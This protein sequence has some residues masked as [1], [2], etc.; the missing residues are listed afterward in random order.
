MWLS[1]PAGIL[2][3]KWKLN[4]LPALFML[5]KNLEAEIF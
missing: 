5:I 1:A 3:L 4:K 2:F